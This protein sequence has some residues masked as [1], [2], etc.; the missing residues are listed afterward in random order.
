MGCVNGSS[1]W[2]GRLANRGLGGYAVIGKLSRSL[3]L[4]SCL[5]ALMQ[6]DRGSIVG[7]YS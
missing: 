2:R 7:A 3:F 5:K 1:A 6:V 4:P